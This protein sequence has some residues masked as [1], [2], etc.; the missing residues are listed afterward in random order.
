M[1]EPEEVKSVPCHSGTLQWDSRLKTCYYR[2]QEGKQPL[3]LSTHKHKHTQQPVIISAKAL[4]DERVL[5]DKYNGTVQDAV[6]S[7][8][9][10]AG[11]SWE[12]VSCT[13]LITC[14]HSCFCIIVCENP[15]LPNSTNKK[16]TCS[17]QI[18]GQTVLYLS[19]CLS[20]NNCVSIKY[21][22]LSQ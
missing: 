12:N 20:N 15:M 5:G 3:L 22:I 11:F 16:Q 14:C 18:Y 13:G 21:D 6:I 10:V 19:I 1:R 17:G 4:R 9:C 8:H 7:A 2:L